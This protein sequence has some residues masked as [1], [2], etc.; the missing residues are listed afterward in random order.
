[1]EPEQKVK[2]FDLL[3]AVKHDAWSRLIKE[4]KL[5]IV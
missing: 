3:Q 5:V 2:V 1:M 4:L